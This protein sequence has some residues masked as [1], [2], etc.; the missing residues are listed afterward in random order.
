M[1]PA[2]SEGEG[3]VL[4]VVVSDQ[5]HCSSQGEMQYPVLIISQSYAWLHDAIRGRMRMKGK[6]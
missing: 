3:V 2:Q 1:E 5:T 6:E 4:R